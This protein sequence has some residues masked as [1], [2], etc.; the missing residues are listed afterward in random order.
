[1]KSLLDMLNEEDRL[2]KER[3]RNFE[4]QVDLLHAIDDIERN[5]R[6]YASRLDDVPRYREKITALE[7]REA[8]IKNELE[9]VRI[10]ICRYLLK[11]LER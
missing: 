7:K 9:N 10:S 5:P 1:M 4:T 11:P 6:I 8:E 2:I 3:N